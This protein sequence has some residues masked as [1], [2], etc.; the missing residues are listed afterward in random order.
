MSVRAQPILAVRDVLA[1][2]RWYARILGSAESTGSP[3]N[4]HEHIYQRMYV[5]DQSVLQ[6]HA[7]DRG[8]GGPSQPGGCSP[9][10]CRPRCAGLVRGRPLRRSVRPRPRAGRPRDRGEGQPFPAASRALAARPRRLWSCWRVR[11]GA[12]TQPRRESAEHLLRCLLRSPSSVRPSLPPLTAAA[13]AA[14]FGLPSPDRFAP[15]PVAGTELAV[16]WQNRQL[17]IQA[18]DGDKRQAGQA[19]LVQHGRRHS[20]AQF[21]ILIGPGFRSCGRDE[22]WQDNAGMGC[23]QLRCPPLQKRR[24]P[25]VARSTAWITQCE[26]AASPCR[27]VRKQYGLMMR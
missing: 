13:N 21:H 26:N 17:V 10:A 12:G 22:G 6:L 23:P 24:P 11:M 18:E 7:W 5:D 9:C 8:R 2:A 25:C 16:D 19:V 4:D 15:S 14:S 1:S 27:W 20:A 3:P